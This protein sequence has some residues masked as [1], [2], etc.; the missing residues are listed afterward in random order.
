M[1]ERTDEARALARLYDVDLLDDPGDADL[2][3]AIAA[4]TGGPV[5]ELG[6]GT[7]RLA[8]PL[9]RAGHDVT[10]VDLDPAMLERA[11]RRLGGPEGLGGRSAGRIE[12]VE[13]DLL[14]LDLP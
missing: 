8:G 7:G 9:A 6:V 10:G 11:R 4:R 14:T 13:A 12:L 1:A 2:Y 3:L 5:L